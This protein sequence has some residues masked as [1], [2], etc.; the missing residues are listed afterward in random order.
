MF[1]FKE[2]VTEDQVEALN[3]ALR[4]LPASIGEIESYACGPD[5]GLTEGSWDY[6]VV[7]DFATP[8]AYMAYAGHPD[9]VEAVVE[10]AKPL[11]RDS[12][13]VQVEI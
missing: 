3:T 9:H 13:R 5:L 8:E 1:E 4:A 11:M 12:H 6:V 2:G 7:A 10:V